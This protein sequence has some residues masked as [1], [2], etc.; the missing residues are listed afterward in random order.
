MA[1][2]LRRG[3]RSR[4][5]LVYGHARLVHGHA[6]LMLI[7]RLKVNGC[8][9]TTELGIHAP[10]QGGLS[11]WSRISAGVLSAWPCMQ[12]LVIEGR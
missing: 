12:G 11:P 8:G 7:L 1:M 6:G 5:S 2:P 3:P 4:S 9:G 10:P